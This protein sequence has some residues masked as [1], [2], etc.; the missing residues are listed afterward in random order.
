MFPSH[1]QARTLARGLA[2]FSIG[3]GVVELLAAPR[4]ARGVGL[5]GRAG[6]VRGDGARQVVAGLLLLRSERQAPWLWARVAGDVL[7]IAALGAGLS[8]SRIGAKVAM[9]AAGGVAVLDVMCARSLSMAPRQPAVD[10]SGRSGWPRAPGEAAGAARADFDAPRDMR[11]PAALRPYS[12]E[13]GR[14]IRLRAGTSNEA[15]LP[16][17]SGDP[18]EPDLARSFIS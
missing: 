8:R 16:E 14:P 2:W 3:L 12:G 18:P 17:K 4:L 7:G 10:Y 9:A 6:L 13:S 1:Q 11:I 5:P 15:R